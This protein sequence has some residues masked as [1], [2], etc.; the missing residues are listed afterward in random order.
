[1]GWW[2]SIPSSRTS[3]S[4]KGLEKAFQGRRTIQKVVELGSKY[5]I[6][7]CK[8]RYAECIFL[9]KPAKLDSQIG[10]AIRD[11]SH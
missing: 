3:L 7:L 11:Q 2:T 10:R 4:L 6:I 9:Y 8:P 5:F 1:M